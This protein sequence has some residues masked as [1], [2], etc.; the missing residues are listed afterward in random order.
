MKSLACSSRDPSFARLRRLWN[1]QPTSGWCKANTWML[2]CWLWYVMYY[3][4][5]LYIYT[6][7]V[8]SPGL[9][10][11][12]MVFPPWWDVPS[13]VLGSSTCFLQLYSADGSAPGCSSKTGQYSLAGLSLV[14]F[15]CRF[16]GKLPEFNKRV[17]SGQLVT[18]P[19]PDLTLHSSET[20]S[21]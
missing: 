17:E 10:S 15:S 19:L 4:N 7:F 14:Q 6:V 16:H 13:S 2:A 9:P 20:G 18:R 11:Y 12:W 5:I 3:V 21:T 8:Q 1:R